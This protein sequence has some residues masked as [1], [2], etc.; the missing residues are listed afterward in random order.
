MAAVENTSQCAFR[1]FMYDCCGHAVFVVVC[2]ER[3][4][5]HLKW[6]STGRHLFVLL[7]PPADRVWS[8][9]CAWLGSPKSDRLIDKLSQ[10]ETRTCM[11]PRCKAP[12]FTPPPGSDILL[13]VLLSSTSSSRA[14]QERHDPTHSTVHH[15]MRHQRHRTLWRCLSFAILCIISQLSVRGLSKWPT[16][17]M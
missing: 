16:R 11:P 13:V 12:Y 5:R 15:C 8:C 1:V 6:S 2:V 9:R 14:L 7:Q 4:G 10:T 17:R 3:Y